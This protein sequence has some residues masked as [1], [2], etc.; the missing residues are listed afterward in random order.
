MAIEIK[1]I[2]KTFL[3]RS[4]RTAF[5]R[6]S[7]GKVRALQ[8]V[9]FT[10]G[11]GEVLG[12]LGSN[13]AGKTTLIKT[14]AT[15][16]IPDSGTA[17]VCGHDLLRQPQQVRRH[18]GLVNTSERSF[19]WRLTGRQN[20]EFFASL[21]GF[22]KSGA[23]N[24][25]AELLE[26]AGLKEKANTAVMNYSSGLQQRL[27]V[28]RALLADP[29]ILLLDEPTR[30]LDP[31]AA[32]ELRNFS[33]TRLAGELGKTIIW[34]TH[35]LKEA[36]DICDRLAIIHKGQLAATGSIKEIQSIMAAE[37][38][39]RFKIDRWKPELADVQNWPPTKIIRNNGFIELELKTGEDQVP[40]LLE[41][42]VDAGI[43]VY[44]CTRREPDLDDTFKKLIGLDTDEHG[45]SGY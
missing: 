31:V 33:K 37:S 9:S 42:L 26:M 21:W 25:V 16:I 15:L 13:G 18:I 4:W 5:L 40:A 3:E 7:P 23:Q 17:T 45:L 29:R 14:L 11:P 43:N 36:S 38:S 27:A 24:R 8:N 32:T 41:Q 20:L 6:K 19:Y 34:C 2:T 39:Y 22:S 30:S 10:I 44:Y 35:N 1:N 12:L 28:A